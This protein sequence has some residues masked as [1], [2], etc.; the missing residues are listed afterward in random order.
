[1]VVGATIGAF[2]NIIHT[3]CIPSDF[4]SSYIFIIEH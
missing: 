1:M 2:L 4:N 3:E